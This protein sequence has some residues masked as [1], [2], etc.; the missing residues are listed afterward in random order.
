MA[1]RKWV[2]FP[3]AWIESG[4]LKRFRWKDDGSTGTAA[5]MVLMVLAH[6]ADPEDGTMRVTYDHLALATGLSRTVISR[7][8]T[9]LVAE[10]IIV[11]DAEERSQYALVDYDPGAGWGMMPASP[12]YRD[13]QV[14][15]FRE[16]RLRSWKELDCLKLYFLLIS[17]RDRVTNLVNLSYDKITQYASIPRERIK[18][19]V[20]LSSALG[21]SYVEHL[22]SAVSEYGVS[23][24]F[25][26]VHLDPRNHLGTR[27]RQLVQ[28]ARDASDLKS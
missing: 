19:A 27:G 13:G 28:I 23:Q 3:T 6:R 20:S 8:L 18:A 1:L 26:I 10:N 4:G 12:L 21:L 22:P 17:R 2:K 11:R 7:A 25:R 5:L 9:L 24:A 16:L 14:M 15:F